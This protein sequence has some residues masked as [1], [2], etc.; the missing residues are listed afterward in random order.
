MSKEGLVL[1]F[2]GLCR[3]FPNASQ[4]LTAS[5]D[6]MRSVHSGRQGLVPA[7][8]LSASSRY[9]C[10]LRRPTIKRRRERRRTTRAQ[11]YNPIVQ[12]SSS[13]VDRLYQPRPVKGKNRGCGSCW[14]S[15][16]AKRRPAAKNDTA[17]RADRRLPPL[18][19]PHDESRK[20]INVQTQGFLR[21]ANRL[22]TFMSAQ[23]VRRAL[24]TRP[25]PTNEL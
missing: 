20:L 24:K 14:P 17:I 18:V 8:Q 2:K 22:E 4:T 1:G 6:P 3:L 25:R 21:A 19:A 7:S 11:A 23:A 9:S 16:G 12:H 15:K 13:S 5:P 10:S